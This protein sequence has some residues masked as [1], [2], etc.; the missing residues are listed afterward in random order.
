MQIN[1]IVNDDDTE[2]SDIAAT[3]TVAEINTEVDSHY[4]TNN[5]H[6]MHEFK[7]LY[8]NI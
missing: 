4:R 7:E 3:A 5:V 2:K 1:A 6:F 8:L